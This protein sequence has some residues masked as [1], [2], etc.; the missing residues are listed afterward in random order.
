MSV[1]GSKLEGQQYKHRKS[2]TVY[3][4]DFTYRAFLYIIITANSNIICDLLYYNTSV[5]KLE[6]LTFQNVEKTF[7]IGNL[8]NRL[9][10]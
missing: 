9:N 2:Q 6:S 3:Q 1:H 10:C 5:L 8:L 7:L 4:T